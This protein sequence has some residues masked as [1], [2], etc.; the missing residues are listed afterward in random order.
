MTED[1]VDVGGAHKNDL[2]IFKKI[3]PHPGVMFARLVCPFFCV[4]LLLGTIHFAKVE[5]RSCV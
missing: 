2:S 1:M 3:D 4:T 5:H